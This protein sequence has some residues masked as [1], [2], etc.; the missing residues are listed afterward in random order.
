MRITKITEDSAVFAMFPKVVY[1]AKNILC[2][3]LDFFID[4]ISSLN[5]KTSK[6]TVLSVDSS[7]ETFSDLHKLPEFKDLVDTIMLHT[8]KYGKLLGYSDH[9]LDTLLMV[10]MWFNKSDQGDFN[11]PHT[12]MGSL[13]SGAFY[14]KT[15]PENRLMFQNYNDSLLQPANPTELSYYT[16]WI[17]CKAGELMIFKSDTVHSTP[18]QKEV[19]EK[20]VISFNIV[21]KY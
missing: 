11:F 12:H 17:Q 16:N 8:K 19:G 4:T 2:E 7:H 6:N 18:R 3:K 9:Q 10:N 5:V 21:P 15:N 1:H 13:F 14:L 20:I